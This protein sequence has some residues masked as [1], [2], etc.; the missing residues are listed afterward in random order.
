MSAVDTSDDMAAVRKRM[1][2]T[3]DPEMEKPNW[4]ARA[5]S[6]DFLRSKGRG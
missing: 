5:F 4:I 2:R 3:G 6:L 1:R